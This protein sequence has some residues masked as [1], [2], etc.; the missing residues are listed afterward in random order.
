MLRIDFPGYSGEESL[1]PIP[2]ED[3]FEKFDERNLALVVQQKTAKGQKSNFN[4][5][6]SREATGEG[7]PK[8]KAAR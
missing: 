5:L 3:W 1:E 6:I 7:R 8:A 2:W 4:K